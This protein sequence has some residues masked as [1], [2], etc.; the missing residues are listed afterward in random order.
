MI[1]IFYI[2]VFLFFILSITLLFAQK[3]KILILCMG[4]LAGALG[5]Y[6]EYFGI[7]TSSWSWFSSGSGFLNVPYLV[8]ITYF[9]GGVLIA[10]LAMN[11]KAKDF[12]TKLN[13]NLFYFILIPIGIIYMILTRDFIFLTLVLATFFYSKYNKHAH[14]I[15]LSVLISTGD[16]ITENLLIYLGYLSYANSYDCSI[17]LGIFVGSFLIASLT[18]FISKKLKF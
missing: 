16:L 1:N 10:S 2:L 6:V 13:D 11:S 14:I 3:Q 7:N 8:I 17:Y 12:I 18:N 15:I 4:L 9:L 5:F